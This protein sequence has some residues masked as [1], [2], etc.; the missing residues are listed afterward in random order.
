MN[1]HPVVSNISAYIDAELD[2]TQREQIEDH[3]FNCRE[4][5]KEYEHLLFVKEQ[6]KVNYVDIQAPAGL[7][8]QI[9]MALITETANV[10]LYTKEK[11]PFRFLMP[12]I[13]FGAI[14]LMI[15]AFI[16]IVATWF[17]II[18]TFF[19]ISMNMFHATTLVL[20]KLP[21][22]VGVIV[23]VLCV[24]ILG[25]AWS[26]IRLLPTRSFFEEDTQPSTR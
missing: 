10:A 7:E 25:S 6:L 1:K 9:R 16:P 8:K 23:S 5:L 4:C 3:L 13:V 18:T 19:T 20:N 24:I 11:H 14:I 12:S 2:S 17:N 26:I 22:F 21:I 15:M